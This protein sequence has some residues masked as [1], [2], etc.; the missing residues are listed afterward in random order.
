MEW[1]IFLCLFN[2]S[3]FSSTNCL[4]VMSN[5]MQEDAGEEG[6][7]AKSKPMMNL[8]ARCIERTPAVLS[9]TAS[10]SP[11][12]I[13]HE[14]RTPLSPQPARRTDRSISGKIDA[15]NSIHDAAS[16][17]QGWQKDALL[18]GC[19][20]KLVATEEHQEHRHHPEEFVGTGKLVVP[21][22][23]GYPGTPGDSRR[24]GSR[25]HW[26]R[27][28]AP[29]PYFAKIMC[30]PWKRSS[31]STAV[32]GIFM[33]VTLQAA[34]HPGI[35]YTENLRST[36][37]QLKKPLRQLFQVAQR[38]FTDQTK[39]TDWPRLTGKQTLERETTL[40]TDR[41]V[42]LTTAKTYV[43]SDSVLCLGGI[44]TEPV[45]AWESKIKW[46]F[47]NTSSQRFGSDRRSSSGQFS[48]DSQHWEFSTRFKRW[49]LLN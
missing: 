19:S 42:Q 10:E 4:G 31:R 11:G 22:Y 36:K 28:A 20:G 49:W 30:I 35:D 43:F 1:V 16:S 32:W 34:V 18:D 17:S 41:A 6:I 33:S 39:I 38:L 44:S 5:R 13:R 37:N 40:L 8:V 46:F 12:K 25:R 48:Q 3:H 23:Q 21:G 7:T 26:Q 14:S 9:S 47:G 15:R 27:L 45:K 24:L 2:I 29:F